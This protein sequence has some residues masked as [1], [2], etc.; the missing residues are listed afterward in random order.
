MLLRHYKFDDESDA[1][2]LVMLQFDLEGRM[3]AKL[4]CDYLATAFEVPFKPLIDDLREA[5]FNFNVLN[6]LS[7][8]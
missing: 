4:L 2:D 8:S 3:P 1:I 5:G 6:L 7:G